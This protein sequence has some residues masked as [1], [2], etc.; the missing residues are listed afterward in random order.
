MAQESC[1]YTLKTYIKFYLELVA[2]F[3]MSLKN[4]VHFMTH[5][6]NHFVLIG[7]STNIM[8]TGF[9]TVFYFS[10]MIIIPYRILGIKFQLKVYAT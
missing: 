2:V 8:N 3:I 5:K 9:H 6:I 4:A 10:C 1:A 7:T